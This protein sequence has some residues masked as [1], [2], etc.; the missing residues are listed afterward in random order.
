MESDRGEFFKL[1]LRVIYIDVNYSLIIVDCLVFVCWIM[2]FGYRFVYYFG[3][4]RGF[5]IL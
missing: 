4:D 3:G 1:C 2:V 5:N